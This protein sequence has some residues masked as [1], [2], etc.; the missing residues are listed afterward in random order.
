MNVYR[1]L[2]LEK[3]LDNIYV[4]VIIIYYIIMQISL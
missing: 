3:I 4:N 2:T 1:S